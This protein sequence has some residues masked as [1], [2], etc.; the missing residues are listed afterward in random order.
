MIE[1]ICYVTAIVFVLDFSD[2]HRDTGLRE[3]W[4]WQVGAI[5]IT[6]SWLN[7]VTKK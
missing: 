4:Q 6:A 5:S 2:C 7:L 3:D 1:W